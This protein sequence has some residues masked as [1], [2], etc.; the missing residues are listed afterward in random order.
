MGEYEAEVKYSLGNSR[1]NPA[2][3]FVIRYLKFCK[4]HAVSR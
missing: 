1:R 4:D 2:N 3:F